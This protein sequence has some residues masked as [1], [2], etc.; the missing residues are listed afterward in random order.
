MGMYDYYED[1]RVARGWYADVSFNGGPKDVIHAAT[2]EGL[3]VKIDSALAG[4]LA[5][6]DMFGKESE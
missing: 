3:R 6:S 4:P 5:V 1:R 2:A